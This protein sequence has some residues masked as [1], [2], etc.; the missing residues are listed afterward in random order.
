MTRED[1]KIVIQAF[2]KVND[3]ERKCHGEL[4]AYEFS[5]TEEYWDR[6]LEQYVYIK[7]QLKNI[8][9]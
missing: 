5:Q 7:E 4:G 1:I 2:Y 8:R 3:T 9:E 6:I